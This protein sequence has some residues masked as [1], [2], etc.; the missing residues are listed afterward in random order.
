MISSDRPFTNAYRHHNLQRIARFRQVQPR[1]CVVHHRSRRTFRQLLSLHTA[2]AVLMWLLLSGMLSPAAGA[3]FIVSNETELLQAIDTANLSPDN[4]STIKLTDSFSITGSGLSKIE[5]NLVIDMDGHKLTSMYDTALDIEEGTTLTLDGAFDVKG[6]Q[7]FNGDLIKRGEGTLHIKG[8]PSD[9]FWQVR[10]EAGILIFDDGATFTFGDGFGDAVNEDSIAQ[11]GSHVR[12][13]GPGTVVTNRHTTV[14]QSED[15]STFDVENEATFNSKGMRLAATEDSSG[16]INIDNA[17]VNIEDFNV[18]AGTGTVNVRNGAI[19]NTDTVRTGVE[20]TAD[21]E[22]TK[23]LGGTGHFRVSGDGSRWINDG[24]F[25]LTRGS[26]AVLDGGSL[27][28]RSL[29]AGFF[30][31][32][33][34][35]EGVADVLVAGAGSTLTVTGDEPNAFV[36]GGGVGAVDKG[37]SLT[38]ADGGTITAGDGNGTIDVATLPSSSGTINIGGEKGEAAEAAGEIRAGRIRFGPGQGALNFNHTE[39]DYAFDLELE[40]DG[41][42]NHEGFGKTIM[43][44]DQRDFTGVTTLNSGEL[45]VNGLLGGTVRVDGGR[46]TGTGTVGSLHHGPGGVI[47]PGNS[48]G[49]LTIDGDY[50]GDGGV[51]EIETAL[52]GDDSLTDRL[53]ITGDTTGS[54]NVS[55]FNMDGTGAPTVEGIKIIEV[56]GLSNGLFSLQGN[57][58]LD[59]EP[60]I[61]AGAYAYRLYQNGIGAPEDGDWYLRSTTTTT[62]P[63][64]G[65]PDPDDNGNGGG[66]GGGQNNGGG[67]PAT[68]GPTPTPLYQAGVP[69]YQN[70]PAILQ[71]L[72]HAPTLQARTGNRHQNYDYNA[73]PAQAGNEDDPA[74]MADRPTVWTRINRAHAHASPRD[75]TVRGTEYSLNSWR[76][77][78]GIE[79]LVAQNDEGRLIAGISGHH[80]RTTA[81]VSSLHGDGNIDITGTGIGAT[82]TWYNDD[83]FY[84]DGYGQA[85]WY[86]SSMRSIT[87]SR[88]LVDDNRGFGYALSAET[89]KRF[90]LNDRFSVIPQA[91]LIYS[92]V[93]FDSFVDGF[94]AHISPRKSKN[95]TARLGLESNYENFWEADDGKA[96]ANVYSVVNLHYNLHDRNEVN[97]SGVNFHTNDARTKASFGL[98]ASLNWGDGKFGLHGEVTHQFALSRT[99]SR[100]HVTRGQLGLKIRF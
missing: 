62:P 37:A 79:G 15:G 69:L 99:E 74:G 54:A 31:N 93:S 46:L 94:G 84:L 75:A 60:A 3:E 61:V 53:K 50:I 9:V 33:L 32:Q 7:G 86:R 21:G 8:G 59:D 14:F 26:L 58:L 56:D 16:T 82:L 95:L 70:Y 47:A 19:V 25:M 13:V 57:Y 63:P 90:Y 65:D 20:I 36:I 71:G 78:T 49:Q 43:S 35:R 34:L 1:A 17:Q 51:I 12:V 97:V 72:N 98:G 55:V 41:A 44:A 67:G 39:E 85:T 83:G 80:L 24:F 42:L 96:G 18:Q 68:G 29:R 77:D 2:G 4:S 52:G 87:A 66:N 6:V 92:A 27:E 100:N 48:I 73:Y 11:G 23:D 81:K 5:K 28:T 89:G 91:Q 64:G 22:G 76:L 10:T 88:A 38:V 40:G 45:A 30:D